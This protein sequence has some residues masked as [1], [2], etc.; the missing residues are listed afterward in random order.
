MKPMR[1]GIIGLGVI[2]RF[3]VAAMD[4]VQSTE[5]TAVCD[6][7]DDVLRPFREQ[8]LTCYDD[9]R[10]LLRDPDVDA[11]VVNV[12]NDRHFD[13]CRDAI[14]AG[15][16]VCVEKPIATRIEDGRELVRLAGEHGVVLF[17]AFHRR[18]NDNVLGL[19]RQIAMGAPIESMTVRYLER[20]EEHV[21][22]DKWYLD[23]DRC[24]GGCVADNGPNAFDLVR[25]FLDDVTFEGAAITR[26]E[27]GV[28]RLADVALRNAAGATARVELDWSYPSGELKDVEVRLTDGTVV[29]ADMLDGHPGFKRSLEHEYVGV[30]RDFRTAVVLGMDRAHGG[31]A[32]LELVE[33]AYQ[34]ERANTG[35]PAGG[36]ARP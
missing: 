22:H 7:S 9:Y 4:D 18:Y 35:T 24:G 1:I 3:Y 29:R 36:G 10:A 6:I 25:L 33:A 14:L 23:A 30:L 27:H 19:K 2:S 34:H 15:R 12:P 11:V 13:V 28:D 21:G 26:D 16:S 20:I 5:I 8:G 17:T 32:A 31:L